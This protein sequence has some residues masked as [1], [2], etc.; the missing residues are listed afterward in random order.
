MKSVETGFKHEKADFK[1][2][3]LAIYKTFEYSQGA[4]NTQAMLLLWFSNESGISLDEFMRYKDDLIEALQKSLIIELASNEESSP[5]ENSHAHMKAV[6]TKDRICSLTETVISRAIQ[7][8]EDERYQNL[9]PLISNHIWTMDLHYLK[10][11]RPDRES[12]GRSN[13]SRDRHYSTIVNHSIRGR[14][15]HIDEFDRLFESLKK[16]PLGVKECG[17]FI[18]EYNKNHQNSPLAPE[19]IT[20]IM[21]EKQESD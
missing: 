3:A 4:D 13:S 5:L 12:G 2:L 21:G 7:L 6:I 16:C 18:N 1:K 8:G 14:T 20:L 11:G 19:E 9:L 17:E 15:T 10:N